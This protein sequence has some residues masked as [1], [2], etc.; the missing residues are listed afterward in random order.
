VLT[1]AEIVAYHRDGQV[2]PA[3]RLPADRLASL[4]DVVDALIAAEAG[5]QSDFI[6][7]PHIAGPDPRRHPLARA[8]FDFACSPDLLDM[9]EQ[10]IGPDIALWATA[11]FGKPAGVGRRVPWHQ[12]GRYWPIRPRATVTFWF[13]LDAATPENGCMRVIPGSHRGGLLQHVASTGEDLV[14]NTAVDDPRFDERQA[15]DVILEPGQVS[16][17]HVD[18]VHGSEPNRSEKRRAGLTIRYMP[19]TA[20]FD[21]ALPEY[22]GSNDVAVPWRERPIWLVRGV[23]RSGRNDFTAGHT[24]W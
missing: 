16:L 14:L 17:H 13:A 10:V 22:Q 6:A 9:A 1:A 18:L 21:R 20:V 2:T 4:R 19:T 3:W 15:K 23:D 7:L 5:G 8:V 12:D 24:A 11:L